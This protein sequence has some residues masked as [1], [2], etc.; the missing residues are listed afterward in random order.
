MATYP[1]DAD[2]AVL[3]NLAAQ[4]VD[5]TQ[6][7]MIEFLVAVPDET[8]ANNA[9]RSMADAGY[10]PQI[11]YDEGEPDLD[12][13]TDDAEEFGPSWT[14]CANVQMIP[15]YGEIMRIQA[16]LDEISRPFGGR[17]DGWGVMLGGD[18]EA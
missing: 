13:E 1:D 7:L 9:A 10:E 4:G 16:E 11:E 6:P 15:E 5:M 14:V 17:S 8:S 18:S 3:A 12:P 2:G